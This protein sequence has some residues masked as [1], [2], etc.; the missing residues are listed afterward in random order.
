MAVGYRRLR[1]RDSAGVGN[2]GV[3]RSVGERIR[4]SKRPVRGGPFSLMASLAAPC[5]SCR[6]E[7]AG[8][9]VV[10]N[11][12]SN[13]YLCLECLA[14]GAEALDGAHTPAHAYRILPSLTQ[15]H[16]FEEGWNGGCALRSIGPLPL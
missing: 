10:C 11:V 13:L 14:T 1:W 4:R 15:M 8:P 9:K 16:L 7:I 6:R 3:C 12:C 5:G 2:L